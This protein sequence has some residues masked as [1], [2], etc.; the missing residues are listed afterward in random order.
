MPIPPTGRI[1][2]HSHMLPGIDDGCADVQEAIE[3]IQL[4]KQAG[5]TGTICTPHLWPDMFPDNTRTNIVRWT[6]QLTSQLAEQ[7]IDYTLWPGGELRLFKGVT[8]WMKTHGVP[9]LADSRY[10]LTDFWEDTWP[11]YIDRALDWLMA[12]GYQPILAHP[13][14][15]GIADTQKLTDHLDALT[16]RGVLLQGNFRCMTGEDGY[17]P[18]QRVRQFLQENRYWL[19]A[20]DMHRPDALPSRLDGM[21]LVAQ[22]FGQDVVDLMTIDRPRQVLAKT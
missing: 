3:S 7:G 13:E 2:V 8:D 21:Q 12:E 4:L 15:I 1:D 22:E 11:K 5:Y 10:V 9:T 16:A 18:D 19:L 14:R 6:A 17:L 20:M